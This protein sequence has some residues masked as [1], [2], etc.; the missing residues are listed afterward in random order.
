MLI[1]PYQAITGNNNELDID[2]YGS[3]IIP[4]QAIT[5][6]NNTDII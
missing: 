5:G 6:N 4:Y 3:D 1:I 2:K